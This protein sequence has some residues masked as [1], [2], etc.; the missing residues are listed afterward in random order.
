MKL[1]YLNQLLEILVKLGRSNGVLLLMLL[2]LFSCRSHLP[3]VNSELICPNRPRILVKF[4]RAQD[5][6]EAIYASYVK[7]KNE[8]NHANYTAFHLKDGRTMAFTQVRPEEAVTC[9][10]QESY[11]GFADPSY[12]HYPF[13]NEEYAK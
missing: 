1:E 7:N 6:K 10:V 12:L 13:E 8:G 3:H 9:L 5:L 4:V 2:F 11:L